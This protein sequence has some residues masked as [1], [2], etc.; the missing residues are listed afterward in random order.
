MAVGYKVKT[1]LVE[2]DATGVFGLIKRLNYNEI[3]KK[4]DVKKAIRKSLTPARKTV[5]Q[6]FKFSVRSDPRKA[7]LGVKMVVYRKGNGG[8]I[9]LLNQRGTGRVTSF[10]RTKGGVS[11]ITRKRDRSKRTQQID[12][13]QG[14]DRAF[15][16][17]FINK[18]TGERTAFTRTRSTN[19]KVASRGALRGTGFF[20]VSDVA[21]GQSAQTLAR[22]LEQ[23]ILEV[24][25]EK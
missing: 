2:T 9:S 23:M 20:S 17:R 6:A 22:E 18:G 25:K 7:Y 11:G 21:V 5:Q 14:R 4:K 19:G 15:I 8:N 16:L 3:L 1:P 12:S 24:S 10:T 13:Y